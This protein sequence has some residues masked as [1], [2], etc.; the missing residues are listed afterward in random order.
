MKTKK[1]GQVLSIVL[2]LLVIAAFAAGCAKSARD[3]AISHTDF[4]GKNIGVI[5][6]MICN[7]IAEDDIGG[8]ALYY[9]DRANAVED[10]KNGV[11]A[12]FMIDLSIA[13]VMVGQPGNENLQV[14]EIPAE[15]FS[16]P[17]GA[18]SADQDIIDNF[19]AFLAGAKADG[20]LAEMQKR[21][22]ADNPDPAMPDIPL[23]N[24]NGILKVA[25]GGTSQPFSYTGAD[26]R[27][28]G[29]SIELAMR[30]AAHERME[31]EFAVM[32]FA[33]LIPVAAEGDVDFGID[34]ITITEE[35]DQLILFTD[36]IHDDRMG[37]ITRK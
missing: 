14:V 36:S 34:A 12:G 11:I 3:G 5:I 35:R 26:G 29:Y 23:T 8:R 25:T 16:G 15:I 10:V 19:N 37:I 18:I 32:G 33:E 4:A 2:P 17:L 21:W 6:G 9:S 28:K 20:T 22:L 1:V 7:V 27:L 31:L 24:E 13:R 30:F